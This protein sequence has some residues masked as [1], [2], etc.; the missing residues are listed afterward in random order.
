MS[1]RSRHPKLGRKG[2]TLYVRPIEHL[3][4]GKDLSKDEDRRGTLREDAEPAG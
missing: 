4:E 3:E 1:T 2:E